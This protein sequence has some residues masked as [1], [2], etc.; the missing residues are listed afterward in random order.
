MFLGIFMNPNKENMILVKA[1]DN[2]HLS[3]TS[4]GKKFINNS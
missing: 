1:Q 3:S 2:F 4:Q